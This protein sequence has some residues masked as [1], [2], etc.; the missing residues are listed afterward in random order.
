MAY[1][2]VSNQPKKLRLGFIIALSIIVGTI[3]TSILATLI[4]KIVTRLQTSTAKVHPVSGKSRGSQ[5]LLFKFIDCFNIEKNLRLLFKVDSKEKLARHAF[6]L[7]FVHGMKAVIM[8]STV[9]VHTAAF[10]TI[11]H[12]GKLSTF[13]R[14]PTFFYQM[15]EMFT[16]AHGSVVRGFMLVD[17]FFNMR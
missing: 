14:F 3:L 5:S 9:Y 15:E 17:V 6:D 2:Q 7:R 11:L 10:F 16:I 13:S 12:F 1:C 8:L 4:S